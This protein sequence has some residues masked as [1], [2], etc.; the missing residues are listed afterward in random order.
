MTEIPYESIHDLVNT[1]RQSSNNGNSAYLCPLE[2]FGFMRAVSTALHH[3]PVGHMISIKDAQNVP[4]KFYDK[5]GKLRWSVLDLYHGTSP[6]NIPNIM[7]EGLL[8]TIGAG[9]DA[10][11]NYFGLPVPGVYV[12]QSGKVATS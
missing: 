8:P 12:A 9:C 6:F 10:L 11:Q 4:K 5:S 2:R 1:M 3:L 7:V